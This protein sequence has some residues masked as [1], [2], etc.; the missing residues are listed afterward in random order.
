MFSIHVSKPNGW[1]HPSPLELFGE[2]VRRLFF[3]IVVE[4]VMHVVERIEQHAPVDE[5]FGSGAPIFFLQAENACSKPEATDVA[6]GTVSSPTAFI[7]STLVGLWLKGSLLDA[8]R[9]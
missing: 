6:T 7:K 5:P 4:N 3:G 8:L 9:N 2:T 1:R